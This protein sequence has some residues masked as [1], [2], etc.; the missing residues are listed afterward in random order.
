M[1]SGLFILISLFIKN[2]SWKTSPHLI[3]YIVGQ[4]KANDYHTRSNLWNVL[5]IG[6]QDFN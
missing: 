2:S 3:R 5:I 1:C 6:M 4:L